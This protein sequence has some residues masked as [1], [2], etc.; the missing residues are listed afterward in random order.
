[1]GRAVPGLNSTA[2]QNRNRLDGAVGMKI[3]VVRNLLLTMN[4]LFSLT[5]TGL[6]DGFTPL[7]GLDYSF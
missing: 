3:N 2:G 7:V 4:G 5:R 6:S 1:M